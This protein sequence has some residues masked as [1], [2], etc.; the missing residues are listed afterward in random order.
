MLPPHCVTDTQSWCYGVD[1]KWLHR[2]GVFLVHRDITSKENLWWSYAP[3]ES[4]AVLDRDLNILTK[5]IGSS[6]PSSVVSDGKGAIYSA[7]D[8]YLGLLPHQRCLAH[9]VRSACRHLPKRSRMEATIRLREIAQSVTQVETDEEKGQWRQALTIWGYTYGYLL[10][11]RTQA[12][13]ESKRKWWYTHRALR[14]AWRLLTT[15]TESFFMFLTTEGLPKTNNSLEG[16][17]R[18]LKGK[19][20]DHRG[21]IFPYQATL[22]SWIMAFSRINDQKDLK[23][24]WAMWKRRRL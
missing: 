23:K 16:V 1:G 9:V 13:P 3:S 12:P 20:G 18:N 5:H 7:V 22:L 15:N 4:Y 10:S 19:I 24:L 21:L 6:I 2:E 14:S 17:N 11:E 8:V